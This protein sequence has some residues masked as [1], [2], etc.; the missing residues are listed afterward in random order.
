LIKVAYY[1]AATT[2]C[3]VAYDGNGNV[4][5]LIN[6]AN[7]ATLANY[8]YGPFGEVIRQSGPMAKLN[9]FRFSTKYEDDETDLLYYG[10][11]YYNPSTGRWLS[12][13]PVEEIR[14]TIFVK[15]PKQRRNMRNRQNLYAF[16]YNDPAD[17]T[18]RWGLAPCDPEAWGECA[19]GCAARAGQWN[20]GVKKCSQ[21]YWCLWTT[22]HCTCRTACKLARS[23]E[24]FPGVFFCTYSCLAHQPPDQMTVTIEYE[25]GDDWKGCPDTMPDDAP[26][27]QEP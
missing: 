15:H 25:E 27:L 6:A 7:G 21:T 17:K 3:F 2:N 14:R 11:R 19:A 20:L 13:D 9:P 26:P 5:A 16:V 22:I 18:D 12:R 8:D 23:T 1:G 4:S 10:Y 24:D